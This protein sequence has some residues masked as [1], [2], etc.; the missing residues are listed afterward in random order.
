MKYEH[1]FKQEDSVKVGLSVKE[2]NNK[3]GLTILK[4]LNAS[5]LANDEIVSLR[6]DS[7]NLSRHA[8]LFVMH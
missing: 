3:K 2:S 4:L 5:V 1:V 6:Y 8:A 7:F